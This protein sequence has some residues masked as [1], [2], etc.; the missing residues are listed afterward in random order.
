VNE[1]S[2]GTIEATK[3]QKNFESGGRNHIQKFVPHF[4][5]FAIMGAEANSTDASWRALSYRIPPR[6]N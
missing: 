3:H 1:S 2:V 6:N 4:E 5:C